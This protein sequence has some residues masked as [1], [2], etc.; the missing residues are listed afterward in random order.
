[1]HGIR[2]PRAHSITTVANTI[3]TNARQL[4]GGTTVCVRPLRCCSLAS[5]VASLVQIPYD[6]HNR[7]VVH[8]GCRDHAFHAVLVW[9]YLLLILVEPGTLL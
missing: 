1:M 2:V 7:I 4:E 5:D 8:L 9:T 3:R 6:E